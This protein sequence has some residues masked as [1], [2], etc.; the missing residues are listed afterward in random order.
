MKKNL[1]LCSLLIISLE[2][3]FSIFN[4]ISLSFN[5]IL[6]SI[7]SGSLFSLVFVFK[8]KTNKNIFVFL[9][10]LLLILYI[11]QHLYFNIFNSFLSVD[12]LFNSGDLIKFGDSIIKVLLSNWYVI[13]IYILF[14]GLIIYLLRKVELVKHNKKSFISNCIFVII[15]I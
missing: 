1:I 11:V 7:L 6:F 12:S 10:I 15:Y 3:I 8:S 5:M 4:N 14:I 9:S 13:F 2:L